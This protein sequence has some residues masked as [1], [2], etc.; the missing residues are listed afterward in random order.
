MRALHYRRAV[1]PEDDTAAPALATTIDDELRAIA[2]I[3]DRRVVAA[4]TQVGRYQVVRPLGQGGMG[5]VY[6]ARDA[7]LARSVAL[8]LVRLRGVSPDEAGRRVRREAQTMAQLPSASVVVVYEIGSYD[9]QLFIAMELMAGGTLRA[10]MAEPRSWRAVVALFL[11][12][13][14]GLAAAH[15][16]GIVHRDFKPENVLL[17]A[18][19][20]VRIAD[21]GLARAIGPV[22]TPEGDPTAS[23][24]DG[25][26]AYMAPEQL[27][28]EPA[29]QRADQFSFAV[30]CYEALEGTR[31]YQPT[32]DI[33]ALRPFART[34]PRWLRA[35]LT[36][37]LARDPAD[38]W[39]SLVAML[40]AIEARTR[41]DRR[42]L[43][44]A[45]IVAGLAVAITATALAMRPAAPVASPIAWDPVLVA[46]LP[47][48]DAAP[49]ATAWG[50]GSLVYSSGREFWIQRRGTTDE[51]RRTLPDEISLGTWAVS[52]DARTLF[53][54]GPRGD[55][56]QIW[57]LTETGAHD[58]VDVS[59]VGQVPRVSPDGGT[60]LVAE[61]ADPAQVVNVRAV[62]LATRAPRELVHGAALVTSAWAPDSRSVALVVRGREDEVAIVDVASGAQHS[63]GTSAAI[64]A[65]AWIAPR[66]L[67]VAVRVGPRSR[68]ETWLLDAAGRRTAVTPLDEL[69]P[70]T[71]V[72]ALNAT[73]G[74]LYV[75]TDALD[76][77]LY[78]L[79]L[80]PVAPAQRLD[81][82]VAQDLPPIGW[83]SHGELVFGATG[84][85]SRTLALPP[86]GP[87][88]VLAGDRLPAVMIDDD[89]W[90]ISH[91][92][93]HTTLELAGH[94]GTP[95]LVIP[96]RR[97]LVVCA[98]DHHT[99]C[100][101]GVTDEAASTEHIALALHRWVPGAATLGPPIA[102]TSITIDQGFALSDDG[103]ILAIGRAGGIEL[104]A[105]AT[106]RSTRVAE[107]PSVE[108]F[109]PAW[110]ANG[111]LYASLGVRDG[112]DCR[113]VRVVDGKV[114]PLHHEPGCAAMLFAIRVRPDGRALVFHRQ[115]HALSVYR[116]AVPR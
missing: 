30:A 63:V 107:D 29:D 3:D 111:V 76:Q 17:G 52:P 99:P 41:R 73:R 71:S 28:G 53:I 81:T 105:L 55:G 116:V 89:L 114:E 82:R 64:E 33:G 37:A 8:K 112:T 80:D 96:A 19:G 34:G 49:V 94:P 84:E 86:H 115:G 45:V 60:L 32:S 22:E 57:R 77:R 103:Q 91:R 75:T 108:Y 100:L 24:F 46:S 20:E 40:D 83:T 69:A 12:V 23:R 87:P 9:G 98:A 31:P 6:E 109:N 42:A 110:A 50:D 106:G 93:D 65:V 47:S 18:H 56:F 85:A 101:V 48:I 72:N 39:G 62:D 61:A 67:V 16:A 38:R 66:A 104:L 59:V 79:G 27:R 5:T 10:W 78:Q 35:I 7:E 2:R 4:G 88:R 68:L 92:G 54:A 44:L 21:F 74:A 97:A 13:G 51:L 36:R 14:R 11:Q 43:G 26:P 90:L 113:I 70:L 15:A 102:A 1:S 25:T 58:V 95:A